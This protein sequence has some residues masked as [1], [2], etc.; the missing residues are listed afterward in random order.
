[1]DFNQLLQS[2]M[3]RKDAEA[4]DNMFKQGGFFDKF[5]PQQ[6]QGQGQGQG[7]GFGGPISPVKPMMASYYDNNANNNGPKNSNTNANDYNTNYAD[8]NNNRNTSI[9]NNNNFQSTKNNNNFNFD[10]PSM[11]QKR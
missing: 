4:V 3:K 1:M 10:Y 8:K 6:N 11:S 7:Q 5:M 9:N 2:E